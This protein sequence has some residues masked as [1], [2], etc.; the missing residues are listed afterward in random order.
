M[1]KVLIFLFFALS[2]FSCQK[3]NDCFK[4]SGKEIIIEHSLADFDTIYVNNVFNVEL[5]QDTINKLSIKGKEAFVKSTNFKIENNSLILNNNHK[6]KFAKPKDKDITISIHVKQISRIVLGAAS[7]IISK[8]T[9][10]NPNEIGL[11]IKSKYNEANLDVDAR[12]FYFWNVHLNGGK[13][14]VKGNVDI[15]K[16][17]NVSLMSVDASKL[18]AKNALVENSSKGN[19]WVDVLNKIDCKVTSTGN[20]Y[21]YGNPSQVFYND[22]SSLGGKLIFK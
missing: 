9:L 1:N 19:C 7:K 21:C 3:A 8:N 17:W 10:T 6:C 22:S 11:I 15:V 5:F 12:V 20:V 16:L 4:S 14:Y 2:I 13:V 18:K